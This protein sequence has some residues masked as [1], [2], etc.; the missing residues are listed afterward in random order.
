MKRLQKYLVVD[1]AKATSMSAIVLTLLMTIL[2]IFEP[3]R[4][5]GLAPEQVLLLFGFMLPIMLSLTL[6]VAAVFGATLV[7]GRFSQDNEFLACRASGVATWDILKPAL[8]LGGGVTI[9]ALILC[10]F[11]AP[12]LAGHAGRAILSN[13]EGIVF[14]TLRT[15]GTIEKGR[16]IIRADKVDVHERR[17][18]GVVVIIRPNVTELYKM[19]QQVAKEKDPDRKEALQRSLDD[20]Q[21]DLVCITA[22]WA[23]VTGFEPKDDGRIIV[24]IDAHNPQGVRIN[25]Y[26]AL[27]ED[28]QDV[29]LPIEN[30]TRQKVRWYGWG[31]LIAL[32]RDPTKF[33]GVQREL[34]EL[35]SLIQ[36]QAFL[37]E[38]VKALKDK[39]YEL[40]VGDM[41]LRIRSE[42]SDWDAGN[43]KMVLMWGASNSDEDDLPVVVELFE[44]GKLKQ[45]M[46][47]KS[48]HLMAGEGLRGLE[49]VITL[50]LVGE[51]HVVPADPA[52]A[53]YRRKGWKQGQIPLPI[54][55]QRETAEGLT[56][57]G[58]RETQER[59]KKTPQVYNAITNLHE[60]VIPKLMLEI[61]AEMHQRI[62][63]GVSCLI[64]VAM[65]AALGL[66]FKGGQVVVAFALTVIPAVLVIAMVYMGTTIMQNPDAPIGVGMAATWGGIGLI[67]LVN[68]VLYWRLSRK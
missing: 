19:R 22:S 57:A 4:K 42:R 10:N 20:K 25:E 28:Y 44:S 49:T 1:L 62:A 11:V 41:T 67:S 48:G 36:E 61:T 59:Y 12:A 68:V 35:R 17:L 34:S 7:Y 18:D 32:R 40:T 2:G 5:Q 14:N 47:A 39:W 23:R 26:G 9:V 54:H 33:V 65:G 58:L 27:R 52:E 31:Q 64:M 45:T 66:V 55:I 51:V 60:K 29:S 37:E 56:V 38:A 30:P 15:R 3:M 43:E 63:Y 8:A 13:I 24:G 6:P 21:H 46:Y 50:G 16:F 53:S